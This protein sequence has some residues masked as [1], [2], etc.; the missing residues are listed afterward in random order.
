VSVNLKAYAGTSL[1]EEDFTA[2]RVLTETGAARAEYS[3]DRGVAVGR[4]LAELHEGRLVGCRCQQCQRI[5]F[6]PRAF[7]EECFHPTTEWVQLS[8]FGTIQTFAICHIAWDA[9]RVSTP[10]IPAVVAIDGAS[11]GM[12]LLHLIGGVAPEKV[13]VGQRVRAVWRAPEQRKG[14]ITDIEYFTP[15]EG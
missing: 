14:D 9:T 15:V 1:R 8:D 2:G 6:P 7:C 12:G 13:A 10:S 3:W 4:Y 5:L 11:P